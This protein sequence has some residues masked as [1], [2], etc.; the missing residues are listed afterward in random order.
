M[1][2]AVQRLP[3][4]KQSPKVTKRGETSRKEELIPLKQTKL[5]VEDTHK[6]LLK[7][8][9]KEKGQEDTHR[10]DSNSK[11]ESLS[12]ASGNNNVVLKRGL[13]PA[14][15]PPV[16]PLVFKPVKE[17]IRLH[18]DDDDVNLFP[19]EI[20]D[21]TAVQNSSSEADTTD[22]EE[23]MPV[24]DHELVLN[25]NAER[26]PKNSLDEDAYIESL[27]N[28][29]VDKRLE[30][31]KKE[32][33]KER[34]SKEGGN[35]SKEQINNQNQVE[36]REIVQN[37]IRN[38]DTVKSPSDTTIYQPALRFRSPP[39]NVGEGGE[40]IINQISDFVGGIRMQSEGQIA[41]EAER[42]AEP[43]TSGHGSNV[44]RSIERELVDPELEA[45]QR[46]ADQSITDAEKFKATVAELPGENLG[47]IMGNE[48]I[49]EMQN[50]VENFD[51]MAN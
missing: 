30:K 11:M 44:R 22:G 37:V 14:I 15:V 51:I 46:Q 17:V 19:A 24:E 2:A 45:A 4:Q 38:N 43:G 41:P 18:A 20:E 6:V 1:M 40:K 39:A 33:E 32:W 29:L 5:S 3:K 35:I 21:D 42:A 49:V 28:R 48:A 25:V 8:D 31:E 36:P 47:P 12:D 26:T 50:P 23:I 34:Q 10:L 13:Q 16:K 27:V 9:S 7:T